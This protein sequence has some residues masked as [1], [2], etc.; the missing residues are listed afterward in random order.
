MS[1]LQCL[2]YSEG[3]KTGHSTGHSTLLP[4]KISVGLIVFAQRSCG[5]P[6][7]EAL[8]ARLDG[9]LGSSSHSRGLELDDL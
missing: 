5:G 1:F 4:I 8:K 7:L 9:A 3:P 2:S 6:Y